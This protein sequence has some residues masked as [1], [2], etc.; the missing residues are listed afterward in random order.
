MEVLTPAQWF[1]RGHDHVG[2]EKGEGIF[3]QPILKA[4]YYVWQPPPAAMYIALE[5]LRV[6]RLKRQESLHVVVC[7]KLLTKEWRRQLY[8]T[9]RLHLLYCSRM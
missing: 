4:G 3:I 5:Q 7:A 1:T 6:A 2:Y 8:R 9:R